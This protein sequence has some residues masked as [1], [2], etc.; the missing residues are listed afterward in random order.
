MKIFF[1]VITIFIFIKFSGFFFLSLCQDDFL[2]SVS[3]VSGITCV[4][5]A[6]AK[7]MLGRVLTSRALITDGMTHT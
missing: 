7:F 1:S 2:F 6:V 5:L 4:I 3:I